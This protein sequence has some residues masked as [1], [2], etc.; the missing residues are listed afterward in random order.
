MLSW[1]MINHLLMALLLLCELI[2]TFSKP[3]EDDNLSNTLFDEDTTSLNE[4]GNLF[5]EDTI[6]LNS[7]SFGN[8]H[9]ENDIPRL[10]TVATP[11]TVGPI[12]MYDEI[13]GRRPIFGEINRRQGWIYD[14]NVHRFLVRYMRRQTIGI[15]SDN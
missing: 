6:S 14:A 10:E 11:T 7:L 13:G 4:D 3:L 5:D 9:S 15:N 8:G 12:H 2:E 1:T